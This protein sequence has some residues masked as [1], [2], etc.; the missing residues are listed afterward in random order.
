MGSIDDYFA[1]KSGQNNQSF[2]YEDNKF[3]IALSGYW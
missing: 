3:N 1:I 2:I